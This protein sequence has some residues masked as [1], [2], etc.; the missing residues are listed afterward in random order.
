MNYACVQFKHI[1]TE[2]KDILL[3]VLDSRVRLEYFR[4]RDVGYLRCCDVIS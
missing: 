1:S 4:A 2:A 3:P